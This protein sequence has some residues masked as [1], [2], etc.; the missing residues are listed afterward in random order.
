MSD[1]GVRTAAAPM[2]YTP[3]ESRDYWDRRHTA[4]DDLSSGG[5]VSLGRGENAMLYAVRIVRLL[6]VL[7]SRADE[8]APL[9]VLDA[10]CGK[11]HFSRAIASFGHHVDGID[12]SRFAV[13]E[14]RRRASSAESYQMC[15]LRDWRPP[16]LYDVVVSIDVLYHLMDDEEWEASVRHLA[17]LV[18]LGGRIGLVDHGADEDR[19]WS[20][21][22]KTRSA[23][24]YRTL[25]EE[26]GFRMEAFVRNDFRH[27]PSGMHVAV[28]VA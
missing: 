18:R 14:C 2:P 8:V 3:A 27:D 7:G 9:R 12:T 6:E 19:V 13:A 16:C 11:G 22:Q 15:A 10:G 28:R 26:R 20:T 17:S 25:L 23:G 24:R 5:N 4:R 1:A 21:Y